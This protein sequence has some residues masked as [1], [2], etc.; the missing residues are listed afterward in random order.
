GAWRRFLAWQISSRLLPE[1]VVPWVHGLRLGA[2]RG[3]T[4]ATGNIYAGLHEFHDMMLLLH[5]LRPGDIFLDMG[6]NIGSYSLLAAGVAGAT[7]HAFEP[8]PQTAA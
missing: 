4:G 7:A 2:R 1:V 6:A 5:F 8:D 3:M